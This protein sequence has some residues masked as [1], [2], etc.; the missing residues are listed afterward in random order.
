MIPKLI[1][2][3][4]GLAQPMSKEQSR[5]FGDNGDDTE[6]ERAIEEGLFEDYHDDEEEEEDHP[7]DIPF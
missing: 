6:A 7:D 3:R 4:H 1:S 2:N 5:L